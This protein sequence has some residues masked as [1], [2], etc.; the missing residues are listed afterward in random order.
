MKTLSGLLAE[1]NYPAFLK[2]VHS[3]KVHAVTEEDISSFLV[4]APEDWK[5]TLFNVMAPSKRVEIEILRYSTPSTISL[6][7]SRWGLYEESVLWAMEN[8]SDEVAEAL[9][10]SMSERLDSEGEVL[11]LKRKNLE[12]FKIYLQK[13]NHLEEDAERL[14]NEDSSLFVLKSYYIEQQML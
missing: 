13:F 14:I 6:V 8:A 9:I 10:L 7:K 5:Q 1:N 2:L 4:D 11:L 12:L 3:S